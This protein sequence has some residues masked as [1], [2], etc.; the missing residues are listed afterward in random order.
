MII[1]SGF[2]KRVEIFFH[3]IYSA[4]TNSIKYLFY[5]KIPQ[6]KVGTFKYYYNLCLILPSILL[7]IL[8]YSKY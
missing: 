7:L 3:N 4:S 1:A 2:I 5:I 6:T 8:L